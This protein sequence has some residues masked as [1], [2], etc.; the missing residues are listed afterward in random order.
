MWMFLIVFLCL[1]VG[2]CLVQGSMP[3]GW[4]WGERRGLCHVLVC[5][6]HD[7]DLVAC[8]LYACIIYCHCIC[9]VTVDQ[10]IRRSGPS[11]RLKVCS[12]W[13]WGWIRYVCTYVWQTWSGWIGTPRHNT[14]K[15]TFTMPDKMRHRIAHKFCFR[16]SHG[17]CMLCS[18]PL[19]AVAPCL[20]ACKG[21]GSPDSTKFAGIASANDEK[22][23][24][25]CFGPSAKECERSR[26]A[27]NSKGTVRAM[28]SQTLVCIAHVC[29]L[30]CAC[31]RMHSCFRVSRPVHT[32]HTSFTRSCD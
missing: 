5:T 9:S 29:V 23:N 24:W 26:F 10:D 17:R 4:H 21:G 25:S 7:T 11:F 20:A 22:R 2:Q 8:L 31:I 14:F 32:L 3:V 12:K 15:A 18:I 6:Y 27:R 1:V 13:N 28:H 16:A 30:V 19:P